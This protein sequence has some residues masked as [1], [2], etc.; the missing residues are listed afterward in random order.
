MLTVLLISIVVPNVSHKNIT[1]ERRK[2]GG[3][4][5]EITLMLFV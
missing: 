1:V 2:T 3:V 5:A 4:K